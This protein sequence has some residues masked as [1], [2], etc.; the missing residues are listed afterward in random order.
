[1]LVVSINLEGFGETGIGII[2]NTG[3]GNTGN[4]FVAY[5]LRD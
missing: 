4:G 2:W 3:S 5:N 1:V